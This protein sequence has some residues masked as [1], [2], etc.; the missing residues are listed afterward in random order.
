MFTAYGAKYK[1]LPLTV[2]FGTCFVKGC[3]ADLVTQVAIEGKKFT[4]SEN[5]VD[6]VRNLAFGVWSGVY[7]GSF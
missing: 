5:K 2:A 6:W 7:L 3:A 4:S 1:K